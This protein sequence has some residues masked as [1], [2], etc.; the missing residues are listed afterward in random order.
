MS[1]AFAA[2]KRE[3]RAKQAALDERARFLE[4]EVNN[5][6]ELDARTAIADRG[7]GKLRLVQ[8]AG[9][10]IHRGVAGN[11]THSSTDTHTF[12]VARGKMLSCETQTLKSSLFMFIIPLIKPHGGQ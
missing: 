12:D 7:M 3:I 2:K 4:Q 8:Q 1:K 11:T 9:N 6:K 5:N 10:K